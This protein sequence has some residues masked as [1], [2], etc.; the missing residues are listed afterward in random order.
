[1]FL[2]FDLHQFSD[3]ALLILRIALAAIFWV[4]GRS[5]ARMWKMQPGPQLPAG[6]LNLMRVLSIAEPLGALA[7]LAGNLSQLAAIGFII[8]MCGVI[9]M[10]IRVW[11]TP[12][13]AHD[14]TGWEL[15]LLTLAASIALLI[16]GPGAYTVIQ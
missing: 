1:M 14:K 12:F 16:L 3:Y 2:I 7:T 5:K 11:K 13:T 9:Y 15:D 8:L 10:K 6:M 4:H